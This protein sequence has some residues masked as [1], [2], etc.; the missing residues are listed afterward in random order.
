MKAGALLG[1]MALA[2]FN[3]VAVGLLLHAMDEMKE[4]VFMV[5]R[6]MA[7]WRALVVEMANVPTRE[8]AT[9][10]DPGDPVYMWT[11]NGGRVLKECFTDGGCT[12]YPG[13]E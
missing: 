10:L 1:V 8:P 6:D 7:A 11:D 13:A 3:V 2:V 9:D 5:E 4:R 12:E